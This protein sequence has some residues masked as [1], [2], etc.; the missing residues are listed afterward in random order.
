MKRREA[1]VAAVLWLALAGAA[2]GHAHTTDNGAPKEPAAEEPAP[3]HHQAGA[4]KRDPS[5][6][7]VAE[8]AGALL[9]PGAEDKIREKLHAGDEPLGKAL[10]QFQHDHDLPVTGQP[11]HETVSKLG[12]KPDDI[13]LRATPQ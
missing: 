9:K 13:F 5:D 2:C 3:H 6:T 10:K 12:L 1:G 8:S 7:P 11:D 4:T